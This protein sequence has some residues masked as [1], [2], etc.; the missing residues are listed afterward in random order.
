MRKAI[1]TLFATLTLLGL[2]AL[3][4]PAQ[5]ERDTAK[6]YAT[7]SNWSDSGP[8]KNNQ[9]GFTVGA[10]LK[11][12]SAGYFKASGAGEFS[13]QYND[14]AHPGEIY[15]VDQYMFG[16]KLSYGLL[17]NRF[18][19]FGRVQF[20]VT[21]NRAYASDAFTKSF[22]F[23]LDINAGKFFVRALTLDRQ[24]VEGYRP[25]VTRI[26]TGIGVRF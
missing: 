4:T 20:G 25:V 5:D 8:M 17:D 3:P 13:R 11:V 21:R 15:K 14:D 26:G 9:Q 18:E 7:F 1:Y 24:Y 10:E 22:G 23:G 6:A 12:F 16:P 19:A 2:T